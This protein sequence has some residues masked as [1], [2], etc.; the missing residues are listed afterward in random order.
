LAKDLYHNCV[1]TALEQE[2]WCITDDPLTLKAGRR[3][4]LVDLGAEQLFGAERRGCKIA[5]EVKSFLNPSPI[6]DL[7]QALGQFVLYSKVLAQKEPDRSLYLALPQ[8][9][10]DDLFTDEIGQILLETTDLR[11]LVFEPTQEILTRW[12]PP[13]AMLN[14]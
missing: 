13:I 6:Y 11:L 7:E 14:F 12:L 9:V 1:R 5:V 10:F 3:K 2:G 4:V 8:S